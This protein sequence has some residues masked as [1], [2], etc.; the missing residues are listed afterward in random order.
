[1][2]SSQR[3]SFT[4][5]EIQKYQELNSERGTPNENIE[6]AIET[7]K[8]PEDSRYPKWKHISRTFKSN[9]VLTETCFIKAVLK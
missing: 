4:Q 1:M 8:A 3:N 6:Y 5:E 2:K 9:F 7:G